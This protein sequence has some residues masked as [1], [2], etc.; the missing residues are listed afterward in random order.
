[1]ILD[2]TSGT[3]SKNYR[4]FVYDVDNNFEGKKEINNGILEVYINVNK[5]T[6]SKQEN[7]KIYNKLIELELE[8]YNECELKK[9][10]SRFNL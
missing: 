1:M 5:N 9:N 3:S 7:K 8:V 6:L 4:D 2:L 10:V